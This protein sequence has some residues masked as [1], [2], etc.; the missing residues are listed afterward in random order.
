MCVCEATSV[1]STCSISHPAC[2]TRPLPAKY[3]RT[4][5]PGSTPFANAWMPARNSLRAAS[6]SSVVR[7]PASDSAASTMR[8]PSATHDSGGPGA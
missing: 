2:C 5:A 3:T 4:T 7:K 1:V 6:C 8:A